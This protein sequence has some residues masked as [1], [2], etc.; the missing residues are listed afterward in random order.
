MGIN[1]DMGFATAATQIEGGDADTIWHRWADAGGAADNSTP[2]RAGDHWNR[3]ESDVDLL[4]GMGVTIHRMGLEWARIEPRQG[5]FDTSAIQHYRHELTLLRDAGITPLIT[6]HHF[7]D[8]VWF[9]DL[10]GFRGKLAHEHFG[11]YV[12]H[13]VQELGDLV[14]EWV[15]I[16]EPNVFAYLGY[17]TAE[18]PPV[19]HS[20]VAYL[21]V[22]RGMIRAHRHAYT[23]IHRLQPHAKV[24]V[25][26]HLREFL[27]ARRRNPLD[28]AIARGARLLFQDWVV[29]A[30]SRTRRGPWADFFGVN[31]YTTMRM[32]I[33]QD[34]VPGGAPVNNLGWEIYPEGL[35]RV[36]ERYA[37][38]CPGPVFVTENGTADA[39]DAFRCRLIAEHLDAL[40]RTD[41]DIERYYHWTFIDNWE[42]AEG[43]DPRFGVIALNY[44]TQERTR[45]PSADFYADIIANKA[46]TPDARKRWV[47]PQTYPTAPKRN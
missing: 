14:D 29:R 41:A 22:M 28:W 39:D 32:G 26:H 20:I 25:A 11:R 5:F 18:W 44:E 27:P 2:R 21:S 9:S 15:T 24:G 38:R 40:G 46:I 12:T 7:N 8:P 6:L 16:N 23:L 31:Y 17:F 33:G 42:W 35:K 30:T 47:D 4:R 1:F 34:E 19:Q 36:I 3:V 45:R 43:E 10:G 13:V 37:E